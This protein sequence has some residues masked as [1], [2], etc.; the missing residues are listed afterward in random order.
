ML[1][2]YID[3]S[4]DSGHDYT[5]YWVAAV[6]VG[7]SELPAYW[8]ELIAVP[9]LYGLSRAISP[10]GRKSSCATSGAGWRSLKAS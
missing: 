5:G 4:Y 8:R 3:E 10:R 2:A 6:L 1:V 9:S 7:E